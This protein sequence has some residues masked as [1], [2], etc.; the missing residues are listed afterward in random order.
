M[1]GTGTT[2]ITGNTHASVAR[3]VPFANPSKIVSDSIERYLSTERM[4]L[5]NDIARRTAKNLDVQNVKTVKEI[6]NLNTDNRIKTA[7]AVL[8]EHENGLI[9]DTPSSVRDPWY[10]RMGG[11]VGAA[12]KDIN[13]ANHVAADADREL[14]AVP[15]PYKTADLEFDES[16]RSRY[17]PRKAVREVSYKYDR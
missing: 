15:R 10:T 2:G 12:L 11:R 9:S 8:A 1:Y 7:A 3:V 17:T 6:Q 5:D 14:R 13:D 16:K 4:R